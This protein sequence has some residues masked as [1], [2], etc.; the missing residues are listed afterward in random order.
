LGFKPGAAAVL[1]DLAA[2]GCVAAALSL[3]AGLATRVSEERPALAARF[4]ILGVIYLVVAR[5]TV[6]VTLG[7]RFL[8]SDTTR[9]AGGACAGRLSASP[10]PP[11]S[12]S[13]ES[14][15]RR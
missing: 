15:S 13:H 2:V 1:K 6:G 3:V 4:A 7:R 14:P 12:G 8:T 5:E 9:D 11:G 10:D